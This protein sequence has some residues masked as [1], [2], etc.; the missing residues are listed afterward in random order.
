MSVDNIDSNLGVIPNPLEVRSHVFSSVEEQRYALKALFRAYFGSE[1]A[2]ED[3]TFFKGC[4]VK[5]TPD[6]PD[7]DVELD[8]VKR[9]VIFW[10]QTPKG[11]ESETIMTQIRKETQMEFGSRADRTRISKGTDLFLSLSD[12]ARKKLVEEE[13][14]R[15]GPN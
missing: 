15:T 9:V 6:E 5:F 10:F 12:E 2:E 14:N 8:H 1:N 4:K 7:L 13:K 3:N 11:T